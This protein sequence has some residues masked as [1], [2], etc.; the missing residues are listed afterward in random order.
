M[1]IR[2]KSEF[3]R[4]VILCVIGIFVMA[5]GVTLM[6]KADLGISPQASVGNVVSIRFTNLSLG[7]WFFLFSC[8]QVLLQI[9]VLRKNYK[10]IQLLQLLVSLTFST[11]TDLFMF[12][13]RGL[14]PETYLSKFL[15]LVIGIIVLGLS[16]SILVIANVLMNTGEGLIKAISDQF[17]FE[18]GH[19]KTWSDVITVSIAVILS[20]IFFHGLR[21]VREGTIISA[22]VTGFVVSFFSKRITVPIKKLF[23]I[24]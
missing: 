7:T 5:L 13:L 14:A 18:F 2:D 17:G 9:V 19:V 23:R 3:I 10:P 6:K 20:L 21:G 1:N 8:L 12:I 15:V 16:I 22:L 4:R 24:S 11:F